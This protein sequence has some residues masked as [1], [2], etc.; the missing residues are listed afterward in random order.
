MLALKLAEVDW[1]HQRT[2][3]WPVLLLDEV[4]AELDG[5]RR[6]D[7]L[8]RVVELPQ[9]MVTAADIEMFGADFRGKASV[10]QVRAG[11]LRPGLPDAQADAG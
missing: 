2:A 9:A 7:L 1:L 4:L 6:Q 5:E 10:W 3:E 8:Q 11:A